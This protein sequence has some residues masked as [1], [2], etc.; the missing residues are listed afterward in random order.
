MTIDEEDDENANIVECPHCQEWGIE[1]PSREDLYR[2]FAALPQTEVV[3]GEIAVRCPGCDHEIILQ[4]SP[5]SLADEFLH[6]V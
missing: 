6:N 1:V 2:G 5:D 4:P 3:V